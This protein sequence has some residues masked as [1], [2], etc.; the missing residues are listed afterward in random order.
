VRALQGDFQGALDLQRQAG[1]VLEVIGDPSLPYQY[2][3]EV[4]LLVGMG[5]LDDAL[6]LADKSLSLARG[7]TGDLI[8]ALS[9]KAQVAEGLGH[10][11]L[12]L[13]VVDEGISV[14]RAAGDSGWEARF[15]Y[16]LVGAALDCGDIDS[17]RQAIDRALSLLDAMD[18]MSIDDK[19]IQARLLAKRA[20]LAEDDG[21]LDI[22]EELL[23][24]ASADYSGWNPTYQAAGLAELARL[25]DRHG[26]ADGARLAMNQAI[27]LT[28]KGRRISAL[29]HRSVLAEVDG[30]L[31]AALQYTT[32]ALAESKVNYSGD[33]PAAARRR[34]A[35]LAELGS[36]DEAAAAAS[37]ALES[38]A[39]SRDS[40]GRA[41]SH[42]GRARVRIA[43]DDP[44][45]ARQD[46]RESTRLAEVASADD[47]LDLAVTHAHL[48]L[49]DGRGDRAV[50]LWSAVRD[51]RAA[52]T[53]VAPRLSRRFEAPLVELETG[54]VQPAVTA[55]AA[56]DAL[57]SL[58]TE[59][60]A[61]LTVGPEDP[62]DGSGT[63]P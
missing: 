8:L 51:Y 57:R 55:R 7:G 24:R 21:E 36:L 58:V 10:R 26:D 31:E 19:S 11:N 39:E 35:L 49:L 56:L 17:G 2:G 5:R 38:E 54:P 12:L 48:A 33:F 34:A 42:L 47:Q 22:A 32:E 9:A 50:A 28:E 44:D 16:Q 6:V 1:Q 18:A 61:A 4:N 41:R 62:P 43:D 14:T 45:R 27:A 13:G 40:L 53:R 3:V 59:E 46:L 63:S 30:H 29:H 37:E 60:F 23:R 15:Q 25:L 52:T 20:G